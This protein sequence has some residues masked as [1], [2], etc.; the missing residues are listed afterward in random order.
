MFTYQA[1]LL[2][3]PACKRLKPKEHFFVWPLQVVFYFWEV[4]MKTKTLVMHALVAAIYTA[5]CI[6]LG[7]F[8]FGA[9]QVRIAELLMVLCIFD[10]KYIYSLTFA[11]F[12][13]N[14]YGVMN[15]LDYLPLDVIFGT[16]ATLIAGILMYKLKDVEFKGLP[17]LAL[18]MPA[19]INGVIVGCELTYYFYVAGE[20]LLSIFL[21]NF[22][23]VFIG[24]IISVYLLGI[25]FYKPFKNL[26]TNINK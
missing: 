17:H 22:G 23:S 11:C 8:S 12:I 26:Y 2:R 13:S 15:G 25:L 16:L 10:K 19:L 21:M 20:S 18:V 1:V 14:L 3:Y 24:E 7:A 6:A 4:I 9:I 5:L